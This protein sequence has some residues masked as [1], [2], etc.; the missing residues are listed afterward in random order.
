MT[1]LNKYRDEIPP[2]SINI[3]RPSKLGNPFK[4]G[5]LMT[6]H[7]GTREEVLVLHRE[8]LWR[9]IDGG[10]ITVEELAA[11][12]GHDLVCCCKPRACH[13]DE[14]ERAIRWAVKQLEGRTT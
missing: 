13:G 3:M 4:I 6:G 11:M 10:K 1:V 5:P 9:E 12:D 8:W 2:S 7:H 14:T